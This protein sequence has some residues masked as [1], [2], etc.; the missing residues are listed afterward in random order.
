M[1]RLNIEEKIILSDIRFKK[2]EEMLADAV[3]SLKNGM[4]MTS[5]NRSYYAALHAAR[6]LLILKGVDPVSHDGVKT[7]ISLHFIKP[8]I[9]SQE[10]M[11]Y[12][13]NL[14]TLRTDV[15]YG[16]FESIEKNEANGALKHA[17][18]LLKIIDSVRKKLIKEITHR[19]ESTG[20]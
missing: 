1:E 18:R 6:S 20:K 5:V 8:K 15:D 12:F 7:M 10:V 2:S 19:P 13:K 17:K 9:L 11:R 16:D 14:M 4:Y 3:K